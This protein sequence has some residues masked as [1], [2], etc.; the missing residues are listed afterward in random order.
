MR[1]SNELA[2]FAPVDAV[3]INLT[4]EADLL[5]W[6]QAMDCSTHELINAVQSVG[7]AVAAIKDHLKQRSAL[8]ASQ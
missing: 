5:Y 2:W 3:E 7:I 6:T 4:E 1:M 8:A